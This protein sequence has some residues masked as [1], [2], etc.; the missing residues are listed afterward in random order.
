MKNTHFKPFHLF[1]DDE[2]V[3]SQL[4]RKGRGPTP[5]DIIEKYNSLGLDGLSDEEIELLHQI[6]KNYISELPK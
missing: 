6:L 4:Y 5:A 1:F 2:P 3:E